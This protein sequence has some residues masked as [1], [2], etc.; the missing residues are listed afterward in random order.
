MQLVHAPAVVLVFPLQ[1]F[2]VL[3]PKRWNLSL[4]HLKRIAVRVC[5]GGRG[6]EEVD[7]EKRGRGES[8]GKRLLVLLSRM[9]KRGC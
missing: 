9:E 8:M 3:T 1:P 6:E 2:P 5:G 7:T 4:N